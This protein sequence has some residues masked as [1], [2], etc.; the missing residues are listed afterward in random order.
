MYTLEEFKAQAA[1]SD[2]QRTNMFSAVFATAPSSKSQQLLNQF[3]GSIYNILD[4][5]GVNNLFGISNSEITQGITSVVTTTTERI[6]RKS[7]VS[8]YLIGAMSSRVIQSLLGE[9]TVGT[10]V[11]DFFNMAFPT[12]GLMIYSAKIPE[13][14]L[15]YEMDKNHN[16][17]NIKITGREHEP[18][19]LSFRMDSE[20][21]NYRAMQ[22]W[23]NSVEDP[24]TGLRALPEDVEADI[25]INLHARNGLPHTVIM[26]TGCIPIGVSAPELTWDGDNTIAVFDVTFA[27]RVM[28]TGAVGK[29]AINDW[30]EDKAINAIGKINPNQSLNTNLPALS[31]L[32]GARGGIS[33]MLTNVNGL[34]NEGISRIL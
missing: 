17:P 34:V 28:Q 9:F 5:A 25:Q 31:R 3:G 24:V 13:N 20:A 10:Y 27:H 6:I 23:V 32:N 1:N 30:L 15:G 26:F 18:L 29:Q 7:G 12:S 33:N 16:S 22:D 11:L 21:A 2:F 8:K 19:I 14:R 4:S